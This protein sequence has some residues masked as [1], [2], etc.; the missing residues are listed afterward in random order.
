MYTSSFRKSG[1]YRP[2]TVLSVTFPENHIN[3]CE[4][5]AADTLKNVIMLIGPNRIADVCRKEIN[6]TLHSNN[7]PLVTKIRNEKYSSRQHE[8][9]DGWLVFT[10][11]ST[12]VKKKQLDML[13][14][15]FNLNMRVSIVPFA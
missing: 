6:S 13:K 5:S 7:V 3:I 1:S 2:K 12:L 15:K 4:D 9:G 14:D 11:T 10:G 8:I